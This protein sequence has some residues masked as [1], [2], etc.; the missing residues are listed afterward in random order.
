MDAY[1]AELATATHAFFVTWAEAPAHYS[2]LELDRDTRDGEVAATC[3]E[4]V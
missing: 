3:K 4:S 2:L 1:L